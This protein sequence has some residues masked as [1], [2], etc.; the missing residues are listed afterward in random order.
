MKQSAHRLL[1][2]DDDSNN[3]D[4][5]SRRLMRRGYEVDVAEDGKSAVDKVLREN[6]D[7][8]LLDQM[9]PGMSGLDVLRL[10]RGTYSQ[11]D[12]PVIMVTALDQSQAVVEALDHGA[13]DYVVKPVD[14][15]VVMARIQSQLARSRAEKITKTSD[16]L[17]GLSNRSLL[18]NRLSV[19]SARNGSALALLLLDLDGFKTVNDSFGH[20]AGDHLLIDV[21][22]RLRRTL[23]DAGIVGERSLVARIG[24]DEFVI[25]V[26]DAAGEHLVE[27]LADSLLASMAEPVLWN[28][29]RVPVSASI[30]ITVA[31]A[32]TA[33]PEDLLREAD[34]AMY[35]AKELG[36]RRWHMFEFGLRERAEARM[37]MSMDMRRA[38]ERH[39]LVAVYQPKISLATR[40]INGFESLLRWQHPERGMV[41]PTE[42]IPVAEENGLIIPFGE[43]ILR[44]A[45]LQLRDWQEKFPLQPPLSMNVNLS[46]QQLVDPNIVERVQAILRETGIPPECL[47]LE[48]TESCVMTGVESAT[49]TLNQLQAMNVGLKL[50]DFGTGYSSLSYLKVLHFDSLKIDQS[51]VSKMG[52]DPEANAIVETIVELAHTLHMNVVAEGIETEQQLQALTDLGCDVGQGYLF[53]KPLEKE[54]AEQL[55]REMYSPHA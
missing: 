31:R 41:Y 28:G 7:L 36:K 16:A 49:E 21:A 3:R 23:S 45:C 9:M 29:M 27:Q 30:G 22:G 18:L 6:Y 50:D 20:S 43:W 13:N 53:S 5:L 8:V 38:V 34:L 10:L 40:R 32:T 15:P 25:L 39:E 11:S 19:S 44:T 47:K 33:S 35:R 48:L 1:V 37:A 24:G 54:A 14:M 52:D 55:L 42:F 26:E 17:T 12:L 4:M 2:V 46:V 51:F